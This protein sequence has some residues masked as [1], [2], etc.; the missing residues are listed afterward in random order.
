LVGLKYVVPFT[1]SS[2]DE[3]PVGSSAEDAF[4]GVGLGAVEVLLMLILPS[5]D[6][7]S[8]GHLAED[9]SMDV[10]SGAVDL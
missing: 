3:G 8:L 2:P 7:D 9:L 1:I 5:S 6:G 4:M 10:G